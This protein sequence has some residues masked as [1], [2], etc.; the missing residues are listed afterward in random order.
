MGPGHLVSTWGWRGQAEKRWKTAND[1]KYQEKSFWLRIRYLC[2]FQNFPQQMNIAPPPSQEAGD[3]GVSIINE[4]G[5]KAMQKV[6]NI[7]FSVS[8][9]TTE[10]VLRQDKK[11]TLYISV[12]ARKN[13]QTLQG[14]PLEDV[15][16][17][18]GM[19]ASPQRPFKTLSTHHKREKSENSLMNGL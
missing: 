3:S 5:F 19:H 6:L 11:W 12:S 1:F 16:S 17:D 8:R 18:M 10:P 4:L 14:F 2:L 9:R 13:K 7:Q 15:C